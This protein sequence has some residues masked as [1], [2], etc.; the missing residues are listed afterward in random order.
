MTGSRES[1]KERDGWM[2][3]AAS[4]PLQLSELTAANIHI[5]DIIQGLSQINRFNGQTVSPIPVLW[6][7]LMVQAL[8][9]NNTRNNNEILVEAL[10]HDAAE[11]YVGD[12]IRAL[13]G[14][15]GRPM[16]RLR[17]RIQATCF[18]AAGLKKSSAALAPEV[19]AADNVALRF[20]I[21]SRWGYNEQ[22]PDWQQPLGIRE[23][24]EARKAHQ[25]IGDPP[26]NEDE[27]RETR[28]MFLVIARRILPAGAPLRSG[29]RSGID[30]AE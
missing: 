2:M 13:D 19:R 16:T 26:D 9:E 3:F 6:H 21:G 24:Q 15:L 18:E 4:G 5:K 22:W 20:E 10:F 25:W 1:G 14:T 30:K 7:S 11:A 17:D 29:M 8:C 27:R 28:E 23:A 12:W